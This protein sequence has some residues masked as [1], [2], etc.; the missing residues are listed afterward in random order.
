MGDRESVFGYPTAR[1][2]VGTDEFS[3][4]PEGK[5]IESQM[6]IEVDGPTGRM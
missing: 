5:A 1:A 6:G 4:R 2:G 3:I